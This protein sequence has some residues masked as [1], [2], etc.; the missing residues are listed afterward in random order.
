MVFSNMSGVWCN[1]TYMHSPKPWNNDQFLSSWSKLL[2][3]AS[4]EFTQSTQTFTR[5]NGFFCVFSFDTQNE[6]I[7]WVLF[8]CN[9]M[10]ICT[11]YQIGNGKS[12]LYQVWF[13]FALFT[14]FYCFDYIIYRHSIKHIGRCNKMIMLL[15]TNT[16]QSEIKT[17][18]KH[19]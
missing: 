6:Y 8:V 15:L 17:C 4:F 13:L 9:V 18:K 14:C 7:F 3:I 11:T 2:S 5:L 1:Q 12:T 16:T 10:T 19:T